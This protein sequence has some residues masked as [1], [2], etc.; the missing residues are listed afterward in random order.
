M[1]SFSHVNNIVLRQVI[2]IHSLHGVKLVK[3]F[4]LTNETWCAITVPPFNFEKGDCIVGNAVLGKTGCKLS[5]TQSMMLF[6]VKATEKVFWAYTKP[7]NGFFDG[8]CNVAG[9]IYY[10]RES[11]SDHC[12]FMAYADTKRLPYFTKDETAGH[13]IQFSIKAKVCKIKF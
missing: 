11:V 5:S 10:S 2:Y 12:L 8:V 9:G 13:F 3:L 7:S 6:H 4:S 1:K